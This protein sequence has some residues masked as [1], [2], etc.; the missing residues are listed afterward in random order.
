MADADT[1]AP[2]ADDV[3][4]RTPTIHSDVVHLVLEF[5]KTD[6]ATLRDA[7]LVSREWRDVAARFLFGRLTVK[8]ASRTGPPVFPLCCD[9]RFVDFAEMVRD[10]PWITKTCHE[11]VLCGPAD[12]T[13]PPIV[14]LRVLL[15]MLTDLKHAHTVRVFRLFWTEC[16]AAELGDDLKRFIRRDFKCFEFQQIEHSG[17]VSWCMLCTYAALSVQELTLAYLYDVGGVR[18]VRE[19]PWVS[20]GRITINPV[21]QDLE[22]L[23]LKRFPKLVRGATH[24]LDL[25]AATRH[26]VKLYRPLLERCKKGLRV[27]RVY[28]SVETGVCTLRMHR[29]ASPDAWSSEIGQGVGHVEA[30]CPGFAHVGAGDT[31]LDPRDLRHAPLS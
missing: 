3:R 27:L 10:A 30:E 16:G 14:T 20:V 7:S 9:Q 24:E 17:L 6:R 19:R 31:V 26:D 12:M 11:L 5:C 29:R 2:T 15:M 25:R 1:A 4:D 13:R 28:M 18:P 8:A 22:M 23:K 21:E